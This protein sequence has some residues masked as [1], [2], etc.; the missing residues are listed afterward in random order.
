MIVLTETGYL[1]LV[2]SFTDDLA[3]QVQRQLVKVY[4]RAKQEAQ[5]A[6]P[7]PAPLGEIAQWVVGEYTRSLGRYLNRSN[8]QISPRIHTHLRAKFGVGNVRDIPADR[9]DELLNL[10]EAF[11][12]QA[13]RLWWTCLNLELA[14]LQTLHVPVHETRRELPTTILQAMAAVAE[15]KLGEGST[16]LTIRDKAFHH[17]AARVPRQESLPLH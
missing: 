2:K 5:A 4:F 11:H 13:Y 16:A 14:L 9:L 1:M 15:P 6:Q 12:G 17:L 3:W 8:Q 7:T 10:L